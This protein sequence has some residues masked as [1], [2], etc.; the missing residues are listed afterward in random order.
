MHHGFD[1][2]W[3]QRVTCCGQRRQRLQAPTGQSEQRVYGMAFRTMW[4]VQERPTAHIP[5]HPP[6]QTPR[7]SQPAPSELTPGR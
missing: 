2:F 4:P 7:G 1:C 5:G 3:G 6:L